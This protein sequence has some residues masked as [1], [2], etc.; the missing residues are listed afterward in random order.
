M[1]AKYDDELDLLSIGDGFCTTSKR[2]NDQETAHEDIRPQNIPSQ[3]GR[4]DNGWRRNTDT[5][6]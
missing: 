5:R 6:R 3:Q 1:P 4:K 2:I